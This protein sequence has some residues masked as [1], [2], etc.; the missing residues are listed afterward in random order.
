MAKSPRTTKPAAAPAPK[1]RPARATPAKSAKAADAPRAAS[2]DSS[3]EEAIAR[4]AYQIYQE[5]GGGHGAD[6]DDWL[7]AEREIRSRPSGGR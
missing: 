4:R 5:R 3:D 7:Q 2:A 1:A 6:V